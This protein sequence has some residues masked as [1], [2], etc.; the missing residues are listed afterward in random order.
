[1]VPI[2]LHNTTGS[3][4]PSQERAEDCLGTSCKESA[5]TSF[6]TGNTR[7]LEGT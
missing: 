2:V 6:E 4:Y 5:L 1:M 3:T 7:I